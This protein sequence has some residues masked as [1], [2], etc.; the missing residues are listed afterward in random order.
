MGA[1]D[2]YG[3]HVSNFCCSGFS[4]RMMGSLGLH[5]GCTEYISIV[6]GAIFQLVGVN[7]PWLYARISTPTAPPRIMCN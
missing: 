5:L 2:A 4:A 6:I 7:M 1:F 3:A